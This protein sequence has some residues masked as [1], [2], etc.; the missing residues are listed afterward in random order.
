M[1]ISTH[2]ELFVASV[3]QIGPQFCQTLFVVPTF[4]LVPIG[5]SILMISYVTSKVTQGGL[6]FGSIGN[7]FQINLSHTMWLS[8]ATGAVSL[9]YC[10]LDG[11][12]SST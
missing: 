2:A 11:Y 1:E 8:K 3:S 9:T 12:T 6:S 10:K 5:H 4:E 7:A